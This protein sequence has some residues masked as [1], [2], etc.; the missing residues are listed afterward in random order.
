MTKLTVA[1]RDFTKA[2]NEQV[3]VQSRGKVINFILYLVRF[4]VATLI[5]TSLEIV[6]KFCR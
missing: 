3:K 5:Q 2:S 1:I 4:I 6:L